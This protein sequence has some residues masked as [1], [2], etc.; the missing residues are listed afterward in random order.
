MLNLVFG[1]VFLAAL[2]AVCD[3][4]GLKSADNLHVVQPHE[5]GHLYVF[6]SD[7]GSELLFEGHNTSALLIEVFSSLPD[8]NLLGLLL[9]HSVVTSASL[10][11]ETGASGSFSHDGMHVYSAAAPANAGYR[12]RWVT[13]QRP[14]KAFF[15]HTP[16]SVRPFG[17][18]DIVTTPL[19]MSE[20]DGVISALGSSVPRIS[21]ENKDVLVASLFEH[22]RDCV[23]PVL[24]ILYDDQARCLEVR[25]GRAIFTS[26]RAERRVQVI[27]TRQS[28][29]HQQQSSHGL[30]FKPISKVHGKYRVQKGACEKPQGHPKSGDPKK[31]P[32]LAGKL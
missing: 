32:F 5:D 6:E 9:Q 20:V 19:L 25:N 14:E 8:I 18:W 30:K 11:I 13:Q 23:H 2:V 4:A 7:A 1:W 31:C 27:C 17:P 24:V 15:R 21:K 10:E 29:R 28:N 3:A 16:I 22:S 26:P 12:Y